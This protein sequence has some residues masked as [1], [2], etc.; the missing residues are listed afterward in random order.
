M[1]CLIAVSLY[2]GISCGKEN[3]DFLSPVSS[4]TPSAENLFV[5]GSSSFT[6][7]GGGVSVFTVAEGVDGSIS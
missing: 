4:D 5:L 1:R 6:V 3:Q 2:T 7:G